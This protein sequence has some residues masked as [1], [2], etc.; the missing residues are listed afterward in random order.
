MKAR[1]IAIQLSVEIAS[2]PSGLRHLTLE[3]HARF[4]DAIIAAI[5][6]AVPPIPR[7]CKRC[8][9]LTLENATLKNELTNE[10]TLRLE[11]QRSRQ[12]LNV[13]P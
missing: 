2:N 11:A 1:E 5:H 8:E 9:R 4:I 12:K 3:R 7:V 10:R 6:E 13:E